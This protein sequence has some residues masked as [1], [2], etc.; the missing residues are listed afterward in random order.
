MFD[1]ELC[2]GPWEVGRFGSSW[3][4]QDSVPEGEAN[5]I[6]VRAEPWGSGSENGVLRISETAWGC[7]QCNET[8]HVCLHVTGMEGVFMWRNMCVC[9]PACV[10]LCLSR[11][12][13]NDWMTPMITPLPP[14][15][16]RR[17][18]S[19]TKSCHDHDKWEMREGFPCIHKHTHVCTH[20]YTRR[21]GKGAHILLLLSQHY[22]NLGW[23][24]YGKTQRGETARGKNPFV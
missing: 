22:S 9:V 20:T 1:P 17:R 4:F 24:V 14:L 12:I 18:A 13:Q 7:V 19:T 21:V 5:R 8:L 15:D 10:C 2:S 16:L 6:A 11:V 3:C 23:M